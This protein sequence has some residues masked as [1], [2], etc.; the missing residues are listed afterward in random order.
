MKYKVELLDDVVDFI[1]HQSIKMQAKI[2]RTIDLLKEFGHTLPEPHSKKI[3][4]VSKFFELR[5]KQGKNICRL[6]YFYYQNDIYIIT[7]AYVKKSNKIN[8]RELDKAIKSMNKFKLY[9][10]Q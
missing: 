8:K 1:L 6:F 3:K 9:E 10:E 2:Q 5:V 7:S 4:G